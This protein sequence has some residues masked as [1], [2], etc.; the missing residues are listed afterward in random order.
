MTKWIENDFSGK[1]PIPNAK[2]GEYE[3][4]FNNDEDFIPSFSTADEWDWNRCKFEDDNITHYRLL[5]K[6]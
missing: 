6:L 5:E 2:S 1:C 3:L 4:K